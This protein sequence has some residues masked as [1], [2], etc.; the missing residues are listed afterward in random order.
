MGIVEKLIDI[1]GDDGKNIYEQI[2][3]VLIDRVAK[4]PAQEVSEDVRLII[5]KIFIKLVPYKDCLLRNL[6]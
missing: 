1:C 5:F 6:S 3:P 2:I 4:T